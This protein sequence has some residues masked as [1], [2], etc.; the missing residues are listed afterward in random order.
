[1]SDQPTQSMLNNPEF[2]RRDAEVDDAL[3]MA[4]EDMKESLSCGDPNSYGVGYDTG[5]RDG[6]RRA[7][8]IFRGLYDDD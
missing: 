1:M 5:F 7:L 8:R 3:V 6:L 4:S 2:I